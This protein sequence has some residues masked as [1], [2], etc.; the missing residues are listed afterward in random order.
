M[1]IVWTLVEVAFLSFLVNIFYIYRKRAWC[2]KADVKLEEIV[3]KKEICEKER[4]V[5]IKEKQEFIDN[6]DLYSLRMYYK[7]KDLS[8]IDYLERSVL[9]EIKSFHQKKEDE[10]HSFLKNETFKIKTL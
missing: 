5:V 1:E 9:K 10:L 8:K 6:L 2:K 4:F 7:N 3:I